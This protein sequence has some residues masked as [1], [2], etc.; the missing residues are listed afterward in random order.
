MK[1]ERRFSPGKTCRAAVETRA[2]GKTVIAGYAAVFYNAADAGTEYKI[3]SD[4]IE[5]IAPDA[6]SRAVAEGD[7][8]RASVNH[9]PNRLLGRVSAGTCRLSIDARGLRY[10]IDPPETQTAAEC[11]ASLKRGDM[12]GSSFSFG[13][14]KADWIEEQDE[15]GERRWVACSATSSCSTSR[16]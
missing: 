7:D 12:D 14:R 8:C 11:I 10:E 5:R 2:D 13:L 3:Y 1:I 15:D 6:F 9:D 4:I 16:P